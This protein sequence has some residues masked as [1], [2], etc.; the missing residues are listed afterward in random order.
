M[1]AAG[2]QL[3]HFLLA[4]LISFAAAVCDFHARA[5]SIKVRLGSPTSIGQSHGRY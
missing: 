3:A 1:A 4:L 2:N 5:C